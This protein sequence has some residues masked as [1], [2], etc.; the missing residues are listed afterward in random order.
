MYALIGWVMVGALVVMTA[1]FWLRG[2]AK[3]AGRKSPAYNRLIKTLRLVHKPLGAVLVALVVVH[4]LL[5]LGAFR[6][7]T[8]TLAGLLLIITAVLGGSF[9]RLKKKALFKLHKQAALVTAVLA[10]VHLLFPSAIY[11]LLGI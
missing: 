10:A 1:P 5:A 3:P 7:H 6:L 11:A 2:I 8:G 9:Y 4:G